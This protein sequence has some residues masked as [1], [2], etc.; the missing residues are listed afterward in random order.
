MAAVRFLYVH[1]L[2]RSYP[3]DELPYPK[4]RRRL[5]IILR[6]DEVTRLINAA[7]NLFHRAMLM[8]LSSTGMRRAECPEV[9]FADIFRAWKSS[10]ARRACDLPER[11][12]FVTSRES[13]RSNAS[14]EK[15]AVLTPI[16][17][18]TIATH[19]AAKAGARINPRTACRI[20]RTSHF[21]RNVP[22][23]E[24]M[25]TRVQGTTQSALGRPAGRPYPNKLG[26]ASQGC[27]SCSALIMFHSNMSRPESFPMPF[28]AENPII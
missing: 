23:N 12:R 26:F 13:S 24:E 25:P 7:S 2:R 18:V 16:P 6:R 27:R 8:T 17:S 22:V 10:S 3:P 11:R 28:A 5:P 9:T 15:I 4:T 20:S 19:R 1:T 21:S 14:T